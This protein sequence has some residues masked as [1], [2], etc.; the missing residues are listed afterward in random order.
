MALPLPKLDD[1]TF[2]ELVEEALKV[3]PRFAP[4]WTD[5]NRHDPGI[6]FIELFAWLAEMQHFYLDQIRDENYLKFL[7]LIGIRPKNPV[8]ART[9]VVFSYDN[10]NDEEQHLIAEGTKLKAGDIIFETDESVLVLPAKLTKLLTSSR[11]GFKGNTDSNLKRGLSF[12]AFE[13]TAEKGNRLYLGFD[14]S[15]S[16]KQPFPEGKLISLTFDLFED[17]PVQRGTHGDEQPEII[18][19]AQIQ[20]E[21]SGTQW[22]PIDIHKDE[23]IM[24][25][26]SGRLIFRA[27][28]NMEA[29]IIK[30]FNDNLYWLRA[31]V[32]SQGYELPPRIN[33]AALNTVSAFEKDTL[34]K[35]IA[36]SG[37]GQQDQ[38]VE[39][40]SWLAFKGCSRVQV[41]ERDQ[42]W[43]DWAEKLDLSH[44]WPQDR[45]YTLEKNTKNSSVII[46]F[47]NGVNGKIPPE[48]E[49]N[50]R[51]ISYLQKNE[52]RLL[53]GISN[54]LPYQ[55]FSLTQAPVVSDTFMLQIEEIRSEE[56]L[57]TESTDLTWIRFKR[58]VPTRIKDKEEFRVEVIIEAK[59]NLKS[60]EVH[61]FLSGLY[62]E[63]EEK[64]LYLKP[65]EN[66]KAGDKKTLS[67]S[68]TA[69]EKGVTIRGE[70]FVTTEHDC[71]PFRQASPISLLLSPFIRAWKDIACMLYFER[72]APGRVK[73]GETFEVKVVIEARQD[74]AKIEIKDILYGD[75]CIVHGDKN[76]FYWENISAGERLHHIYHVI[77]G[78]KGGY[79]E[80]EIAVYM[81]K[82]SPPIRDKTPRS[83]II[84]Q[85]LIE[86]LRWQDWDKVYDFDASGP[87]DKHYIVEP[88]K[89]KIQFGDGIHGAIPQVSPQEDRQNVRVIYY[90]S[91][92]GEK[93]N[94]PA[95]AINKMIQPI[96]GLNVLNNMPASGGQEK[97][98]IADAQKR[99]RR[100][101][102]TVFRA[103]TSEDFEYLAR[104]TP[105]LRV[106]R[107]KAI[108]QVSKEDGNKDAAVKVIVAPYSLSSKPTPSKGFLQTVCNH[109]KKHRL[110]T[111]IIKVDK[112]LYVQINV[113]ATVLIKPGL[114]LDT[115]VQLIRDD[116]DVFLHPLKG[117][118][119][120][121]RTVYRSE[122]YQRIENVEGVDCVDDVALSAGGD[123]FS[124]DAKGN[125]VIRP[126]SL[127]HPGQ[128]QITII[129]PEPV[130]E[131]KRSQK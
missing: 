97:E 105:G 118:W 70:V 17:Y 21:Y 55:T 116:L 95:Q 6:T 60:V 69:G 63:E 11:F 50:I 8:S 123:P 66:L 20:W 44:S 90:Q 84:V 127:V 102:K 13:E 78:Q 4:R 65:I 34:S 31:T 122:V 106:A 16:V 56:L 24:L 32:I 54:G 103:V 88:E 107:A 81:K 109:L 120:F 5:H 61:E 43:Y 87:E 94:V 46:R 76:S 7:K 64:A 74:I 18:P 128:H 77:A 33:R 79:I 112:P 25:S 98:S 47:G 71:K 9:D 75:L 57:T 113:Q 86:H 49:N 36:F 29:R 114:N 104:S 40:S 73:A 82:Q 96:N 124:R 68:A 129:S 19:S 83:V 51:L 26:Q 115:I 35:V 91:G 41:Q 59:Q 92:G 38:S 119:P 45:H 85:G 12:Y 110:I 15:S 72:T 93:G 3:I 2:N 23:T 99:A 89:G 121:G 117:N 111:T 37:N 39:V 67:Y 27:P 52:K 42:T 100:D 1:K 22:L 130:C 48:G 62:C 125:I 101:F 28:D 58:K 131:V 108:P 14:S 10:K 126:E 80:G 30:P 53:P